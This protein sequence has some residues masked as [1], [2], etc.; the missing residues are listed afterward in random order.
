MR[1]QVVPHSILRS[2]K[3]TC[4]FLVHKSKKEQRGFRALLMD[5]VLATDMKQHFALISRFKTL[6]THSRA[7]TNPGSSDSGSPCCALYIFLN[8]AL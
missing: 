5:M 2:E 8:S 7:A 4:N 6:I 3:G 1:P